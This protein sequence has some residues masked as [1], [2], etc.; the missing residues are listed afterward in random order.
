VI[1][2][3]EDHRAVRQAL[4]EL[5]HVA[6]GAIDVF[7]SANVN[8]ALRAIGEHRIDLVLMDIK[9]P[10][11][12][13]ITGTRLLLDASPGSMVVMVSNFDDAFHRHAARGAGAKAFVSKRAI[14]KELVP[15]IEAL[16][17]TRSRARSA[18]PAP[19]GSRVPCAVPSAGMA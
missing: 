12:D 6:F 10:G 11:I 16:L 18:D 15:A 4:R 7:E 14:G 19:D 5:M 9:L 8:E 2:I 13:G 1:L 3:V 17:A